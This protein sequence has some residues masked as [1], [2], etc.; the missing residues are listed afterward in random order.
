VSQSKGAYYPLVCA[1][2]PLAIY[3]LNFSTDAPVEIIEL[4]CK[5]KEREKVTQ[6]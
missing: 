4:T 1:L 3:T 5:Y 2:S 6:G